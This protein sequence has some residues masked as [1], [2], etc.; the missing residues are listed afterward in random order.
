VS[1]VAQ[2]TNNQLVAYQTKAGDTLDLLAM[3]TSS[4]AEMF[5]TA[6]NENTILTWLLRGGGFLAMFIG[7]ALLLGPLFT[8]I[9]FVPFL[10]GLV[11]RASLVVAFAFT[12]LLSGVII[13]LA[14]LVYHPWIGIALLCV[15]VLVFGLLIGGVVLLGR[16]QKK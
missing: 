12:F 7:V 5:K 9:N 11:E 2:Q 13:A 14:W 15:V 8:I 6:Q 4:A 1:V 10:G 16:A 3:G